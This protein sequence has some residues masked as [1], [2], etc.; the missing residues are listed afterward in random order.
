M[1][2][3]IL[4]VPYKCQ[5]DTSEANLKRTDCGPC[6]VAMILGGIGQKVTTNAVVTAANQQ[7]DNGLMQSQVVSA[8]SAF[9]LGMSWSSGHTLDDLKK[10]IDNGQPPIALVKYANLPDRVEKGSTGGHY[11]VVVGYDDATQRIFINDPDTFPWD[12]SAGY[13]KAYSYNIWM[14]AW[15]G[16]AVGENWNFSLIFPTKVGLI[17]GTGSGAPAPASPP[18]AAPTG[19]VFVTATDGLRVR[20]QPNKGAPE[21]GYVVFGQKLT[22]LGTESGPD[23][24]GYTWQQV[25]TEAGV[26]AYVAASQGSDRYLSKS[27]PDVA[28]GTLDLSSASG[29]GATPEP[30]RKDLPVATTQELWVIS[31]IGLNL[32]KES[33]ATAQVLAGVAKGAKVTAIGPEVGPDAHNNVWRQVKT[34]NDQ[35]GWVA[36]KASG[37]VTVSATRPA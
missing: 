21:M 24:Q 7:G 22:A 8:A 19:D 35:L 6:C 17:G 1:G 18:A 27:K 25:K 4:N 16:F 11:V 26:V 37:E 15:G 31:D 9:G 23:A 2:S 12:Q 36:V 5:N 33:N 13:Q 28:K 3:K 10:F 14:S 32:R 34:A 30:P 29:T 20:A